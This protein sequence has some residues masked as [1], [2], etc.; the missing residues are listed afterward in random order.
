MR[1]AARVCIVAAAAVLVAGCSNTQKHWTAAKLQNKTEAYENFV[2]K[3]PTGPFAE[4]ARLAIERIRFELAESA[5]TVAAY[6]SFLSA[7]PNGRYRSLCVARLDSLYFSRAES[8]NTP[9]GYMRYLEKC[10]DGARIPAA[11]M[12]VTKLIPSCMDYDRSDVVFLYDP[13]GDIVGLLKLGGSWR[14]VKSE[15]GESIPPGRVHIM[16]QVRAGTKL[17]GLPKGSSA[18]GGKMSYDGQGI[19]TAGEGGV[20]IS[21]D[22]RLE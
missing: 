6:E 12:R 8:L 4:S 22:A 16:G 21:V 5:N 13:S 17:T 7:N 11:P 3:Y 2:A 19:P 14:V 10:P 18:T 1:H 20:M 15:V 9:E